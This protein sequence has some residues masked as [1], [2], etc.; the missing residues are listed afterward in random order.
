[1]YVRVR[2]IRSTECTKICRSLDAEPVTLRKPITFTIVDISMGGIGII[3]D[4][5]IELGTILIFNILLDNIT[6]EIKYSVVYC[7][8]MEDKF[9]IGLRIAEKDRDYIRHLKIY[10]A[11]IS[12]Q[13]NYGK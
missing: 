10:V 9:R 13:S 12:L 1:M 8:K 4:Y 6:Y 11:R 3:C 7:I 5:I 2:Y